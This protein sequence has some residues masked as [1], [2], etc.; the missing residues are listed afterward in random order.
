MSLGQINVAY[1][2]FESVADVEDL[3]KI[4]LAMGRKVYG[5]RT[6]CDCID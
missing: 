5:I 1:V 4:L 2:L 6:K 3:I